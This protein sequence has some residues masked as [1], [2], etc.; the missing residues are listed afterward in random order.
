MATPLSNAIDFLKRLGFF[1][2]ILSF[3]F[4]FTIVFAILEKTKILGI[5]KDGRPKK[6]INS[7]V[8]L[9]IAL[10]FVAIPRAVV[11]IQSSLPY[12]A[13]LLVVIVIYM[14]LV[15]SYASGEKEFHF[16]ERKFWGAFMG[17]IVFVSV[18]AIFL[19]SFGW[20]DPVLDYI[21]DKWQDTF[22]ISLIFVA[23]I[24]G[25][26]YWVYNTPGGTKQGG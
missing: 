4:I 21:V 3:L 10:F 5:E 23:F 22:I 18:A 12:A 17:I 16:G 9:T 6:N 1:D 2:V 14:L 8:A 15:G 11:F 13:L 26:V 20:L 7:M 25:V 19:N 24:I